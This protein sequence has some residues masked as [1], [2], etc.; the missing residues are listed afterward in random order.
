MIVDKKYAFITVFMVFLF[1]GPTASLHAAEFT[2]K[3]LAYM[4]ATL[5]IELFKRGDITPMDVIKAQKAEYERTEEKVNA[6]TVAYWDNAMKLAEQSAERYKDGT[7]RKLEGITVGI[8][9]EHHDAGWVVTQGSLIH[10][11]DPPKKEADPIVAKLKSAGAIPVLQTTVPEF[12]LN[13]VT[14]TKAWGVT[15]NPWNLKYAVGGSS[16]G[17]GAALA[18]GY[19]TLATGSDMGGS[20]RI[21]CA[22][23][24]L[25]GM[26]PA[27]GYVHT[28]LPLSH[29]SGTGPMARNFQDMV[30]MYNVITGPGKDSVNVATAVKFPLDYEPI[31][32]MKIAR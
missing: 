5:Q 10:K 26:K 6:V 2:Q 14:A 8:K 1:V 11:N 18:A 23:D 22:F 28:D 24:G 3:E 25:Y 31:T 21:P 32:G 7:Y 19:V 15:R 16:G 29:F 9:D 13:F 30:M 27:F 12:Y 4:P 17:S 20:I